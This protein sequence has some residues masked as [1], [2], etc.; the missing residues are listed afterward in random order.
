LDAVFE[1]WKQQFSR[2]LQAAIHDG[3]LP[4]DADIGALAEFLLSGWQGAILRAKMQQNV[5][6]IRAFIHLMFKHVLTNQ[7]ARIE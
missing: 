4:D 6:P 3:E 7:T 1:T 2:C 5:A